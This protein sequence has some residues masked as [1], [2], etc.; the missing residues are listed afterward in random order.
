MLYQKK[1]SGKAFIEALDG[2]LGSFGCFISEAVSDKFFTTKNSRQLNFKPLLTHHSFLRNGAK[3]K[4]K[5]YH[6]CYDRKVSFRV[7]AVLLK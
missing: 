4:I 3:K 7:V 6:A 1:P 2:Y 5:Y